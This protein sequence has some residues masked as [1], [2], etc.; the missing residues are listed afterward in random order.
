MRQL[1]GG[2]SRESKEGCPGES[3]TTTKNGYKNLYS[4]VSLQ[5]EQ[6]SNPEQRTQ[7]TG[8][9]RT[10]L[11]ENGLHA[12]FLKQK[13]QLFIIFWKVKEV[14]VSQRPWAL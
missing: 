5:K 11:W 12:S 1:G 10:A 6:L 3:L 8:A 9:I 4:S 2:K 7:S 14:H 13:G